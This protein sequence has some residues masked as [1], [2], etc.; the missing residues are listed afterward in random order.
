MPIT[1]KFR[2]YIG[3]NKIPTTQIVID[4]ISQIIIYY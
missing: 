3:K 4:L 2:S 1:R